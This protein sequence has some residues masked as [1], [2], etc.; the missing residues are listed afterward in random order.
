MKNKNAAVLSVAILMI[1]CCA[2]ILRQ[3]FVTQDEGGSGV[4][5][6][7]GASEIEA[8]Q[9]SQPVAIPTRSVDQI[10]PANHESR[11]DQG[12]L[13][14]RFAAEIGQSAWGRKVVE[15]TY[16]RFRLLPHVYD[17]KPDC[18]VTVCKI[19]GVIAGREDDDLEE[20]LLKL[21]KA[22]DDMLMNNNAIASYGQITYRLVANDSGRIH[23]SQVIEER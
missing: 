3:A 18:K 6:V 16:V 23:F 21:Q 2:L 15:D 1:L 19:S 17:V 22:S 4:V 13:L 9:R 14:N 5:V 7:S 10:D 12:D 20:V 11:S 8:E